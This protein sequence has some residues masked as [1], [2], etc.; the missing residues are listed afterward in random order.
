VTSVRA[1]SPR[2][3]RPD[4]RPDVAAAA[5]LF[6][7]YCVTLARGMTYWDA[8]EFLAAIHSL[9]IP[10]PPGTPLFVLMAH[11]WSMVA[12]PIAG[13][14]IAVNAFSALATAAA[15]GLVANI[16]WRATG[17][18]VAAF[19]GALTAGLMS[20]VWLN[21]TETEVYACALFGA[22]AILWCARQYALTLGG[23]WVLLTLYTC[24][25][26]WSL[27]LTSLLVVPAAL[28]AFFSAR[29]KPG[30][31]TLISG[32]LL[33]L[34]G[35]SVVLFML[36][37]A[38]HDP[39]IN[40][41]NPAT[42]RALFDVVQRH[43]YDVAPLWPRRAPLWLQ[44]GNVLEYADW[45]VA[46]GLGPDP[47]PTWARTSAT[48]FYALLGIYGS[49]RHRSIDRTSWRTWMVLLITASVGVVL[50][51]NLRAGASYGAGIVPAGAPHEA[52][53]RD[54]FFTWAFVCWGVWAGFGAVQLARKLAREPA[55]RSHLN[56]VPTRLMLGAAVAI[57]ALPVA[58]NWSAVRAIRHDEQQRA[59]QSSID[60]LAAVPPNAVFLAHGDND[61]YPL[62]YLQEVL[63]MRRDVTIVTIPLLP[64]A[65]YRAELQRR[66]HLLDSNF[67][68][69]WQGST[70]TVAN[71]TANARRQGRQVVKSPFIQR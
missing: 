23:R 16:F 69:T 53:D 61:T 32:L 11:V 1:A 5:L 17:D 36:L 27:H 44:F 9:G 67:V 70:Q 64:P 25:L 59:E 7:V 41:G 57:A 38:R 50:Y 31:R 22:F 14:T 10:H 66:H 62:W 24:G 4:V 54:Y 35:G 48:V 51:L 71:L 26:G 30:L 34:V 52:R 28:Y 60:M 8:G 20:T 45:Q 55:Q 68:S 2:V 6:V 15:F 58:L 40:Q 63:H 49:I 39:A 12:S 37:R 46:L 43:Q 56:A 33:S 13:F 3:V 42:I 29:E 65:W 19:A 47:G 21:A 18:G